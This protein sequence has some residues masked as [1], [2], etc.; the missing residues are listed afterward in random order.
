MTIE[1][2]ELGTRQPLEAITNVTAVTIRTLGAEIQVID[3]RDSE[4]KLKGKEVDASRI[5]LQITE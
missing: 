2:Y 3:Y 1:L 5:G 4:G